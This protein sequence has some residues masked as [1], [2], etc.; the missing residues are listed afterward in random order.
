ML[1]AAPSFELLSIRPPDCICSKVFQ[2][3]DIKTCAAC[4]GAFGP[5]ARLMQEKNWIHQE[6][7][8]SNKKLES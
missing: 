8:N 7:Q 5:I 4:K 1:K 2:E 3:S 6:L